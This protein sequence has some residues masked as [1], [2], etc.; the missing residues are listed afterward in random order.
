MRLVERSRL[1]AY[2][3]L[4]IALMVFL[5]SVS[6]GQSVS[7]ETPSSSDPDN[8]G[9]LVEIMVTAQKRSESIALLEG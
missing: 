3:S 7:P 2:W 5:S 1:V 9:S 8:G 4:E 6:H